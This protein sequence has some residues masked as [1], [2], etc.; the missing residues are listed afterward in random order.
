LPSFYIPRHE[1]LEKL[2][3][4]V[5][6]AELDPTRL[7]STVTVTG[8]GG[9]GKTTLVTTLCHHD[10]IKARF[11]GGFVFIKL[12]LQAPY[13]VVKLNELYRLIKELDE[14]CQNYP[15]FAI[16][17]K[18]V[19]IINQMIYYNKVIDDY[20]LQYFL[21][22]M[23]SHTST[24]HSYGLFLLPMVKELIYFYQR[25]LHVL[26]FCSSADIR[27]T[28]DYIKEEKLNNTL[29]QIKMNHVIKLQ[30]VCPLYLDDLLSDA[31]KPYNANDYTHS[32]YNE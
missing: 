23:I 2:V 6:T 26:D 14:Y 17:E 19:N 1:L 16:A 21:Q 3:T 31:L 4:A 25:I 9:F 20:I 28:V 7:G 12:G 22:R 24:Y 27:E 18:C 13:P 15:I 10:V 5:L 29:S 32:K 11:K 30:E 8:V